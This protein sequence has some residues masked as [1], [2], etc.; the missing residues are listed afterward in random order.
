V[1][2]IAFVY[3]KNHFLPGGQQSPFSETGA[4]YLARE[5]FA[6]FHELYPGAIIDYYDHSEWQQLKRRNRVDLLF[7]IGSHLNRFRDALLPQET[8]LFA[9]NRAEP[10]RLVI[11]SQVREESTVRD[12]PIV[13]HD[14]F[15]AKKFRTEIDAADKI[16]QLGSW[17]NYYANMVCGVSAQNQAL[18]SFR[19][20]V[21]GAENASRGEGKIPV[22]HILFLAGTVILRKGLHVILPLVKEL[23]ASKSPYKLMLVG[24][25]GHPAITAF[26]NSCAIQYPDNFKWV[27]RFIP[28][29]SENWSRL[30]ANSVL[31]IAPTFEE[32]QQDAAMECIARGV[33][34][35]HPAEIGF[36]T[37]VPNA[38]IVDESSSAWVQ[39]ILQM[40]DSPES[41]QNVLEYQSRLYSLQSP[42]VSHI[43]KVLSTHKDSNWRS[44]NRIDAPISRYASPDAFL[45]AMNSNTPLRKYSEDYLRLRYPTLRADLFPKARKHENFTLPPPPADAQSGR[46]A[47]ELFFA[48]GNWT[49]DVL[50]PSFWI[51][52]K[53]ERV[54]NI[55]LNAYRRGGL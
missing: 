24:Q 40:L 48:I 29:K 25:S 39:A 11:R 30:F 8:I 53:L 6:V 49:R 44:L 21:G 47:Q 27:D 32:G 20:P 35:L 23:F 33:P 52:N 17:S 34:L 36:E 9:V 16:L 1:T 55:T 43:K 42:G 45:S 38:L 54:R 14:G 18:V 12:L 26:L 28:S 15:E 7:G 10:T 22:G 3:S 41:R 51:R 37:L 4:G 46:D 5:I 13:S 2:K 31:A 19:K 50:V